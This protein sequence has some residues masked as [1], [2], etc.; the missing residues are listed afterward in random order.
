M[1]KRFFAVICVILCLSILL[2]ACGETG[3]GSDDT[4]VVLTLDD[5]EVIADTYRYFYLSYGMEL[6]Q[7]ADWNLKVD[8]VEEKLRSFAETSVCDLYAIY[9][10]AE[11]YGI[12][13]SD[14][15][16]E[17]M[18]ADIAAIFVEAGGESAYYDLCESYYMTGDLFRMLSLESVYLQND[19][20]TY[21]KDNKFPSDK[22]TVLGDITEN[23][24]HCSQVCFSVANEEYRENV[25]QAA[26]NAL[27]DIKAGGHT[28]AEYADD[29]VTG[30]Y[31]T[32]GQ[33]HAPFEMAALAL[34]EG[35]M[36]EVVETEAGF[37]IIMRLPM[38]ATQIEEQY[39][40]LRE[41]Y[42]Q[43]KFTELLATRAQSL[44]LARARKHDAVLADLKEELEDLI[45]EAKAA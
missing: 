29:P 28:F 42:F 37:H 25:R 6:A 2:A 10:L 40:S 27:A 3:G 26:E 38:N 13:L 17:Q 19:L 24:Y 1:K 32:K 16:K 41:L 33:V 34:A 8:H 20:Y 44:T 43:R 5:Y 7:A 15:R 9:S 23:F 45:A 30:T 4:R 35:E 12:E 31:Y 14:A 36:S 11:E 39:E 22:E 21:L 18:E